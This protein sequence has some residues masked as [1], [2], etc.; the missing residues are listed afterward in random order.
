MRGV[1]STFESLAIQKQ[2]QFFVATTLLPDD[3]DPLRQNSCI[4]RDKYV[5][6]SAIFVGAWDR[7]AELIIESWSGKC[8][9]LRE[10]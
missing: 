5:F 6:N 10:R 2:T 8:A 1:S 7:A 4:P 3:D 9:C